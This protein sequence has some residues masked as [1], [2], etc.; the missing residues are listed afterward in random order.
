MSGFALMSIA[1]LLLLV[2]GA[3]VVVIYNGLVRGRLLVREG[4][5]G[6]D[7]Q[8]KRRHDLIPN[9]VR[10]VQGYADFERSVLDEVTRL[11]ARAMG[12]QSIAE[13]QR[14]EN[15]LSGAL[16]SLFA[17]A[18]NYPDLKASENF[19]DLQGRLDDIEDELQRSRRYY[20]GTV[21]DYNTSVES[22][23]SNLIARLFR[24]DEMEFFELESLADREPPKVDIRAGSQE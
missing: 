14:D 24:F 15:A 22:F 5:S 8:L 19:R 18:E 21:R 4:F 9:L 23:P 13:K 7:V 11:R 20:N 2:C 3:V 17:I 16:K 12:D 6:I 1:I 10:T